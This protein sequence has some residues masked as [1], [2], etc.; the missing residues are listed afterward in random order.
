MSAVPVWPTTVLTE[1]NQQITTTSVLSL[2]PLELYKRSLSRTC[3]SFVQHCRHFGVTESEGATQ[4][5][6]PKPS[7]SDAAI[8]A[9]LKQAPVT[10]KLQKK[11]FY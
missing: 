3:P 10:L 11:G 2:N 9:A 4:V 1:N 5:S 7:A 6:D 8:V